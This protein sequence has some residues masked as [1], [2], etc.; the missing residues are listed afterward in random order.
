MDQERRIQEVPGGLD[1]TAPTFWGTVKFCELPMFLF[2]ET[3]RDGSGQGW[4]GGILGVSK[5]FGI[6]VNNPV[7]CLKFN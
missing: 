4:D 3:Y 7:E 1:G 6:E 2:P 5:F